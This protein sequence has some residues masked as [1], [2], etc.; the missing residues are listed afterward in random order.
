MAVDYDLVII[1]G[2][3][4]GVSAA[5]AAVQL[6][7]RV[8]LVVSPGAT[9]RW[10]RQRQTWVEI[11]RLTQ[12]LG[13]WPQKLG[14][15]GG[16]SPAAR[17]G[18]EQLLPW[19]ES[20][21]ATL[22]GQD[23]LAAVA[24]LGV[25]VIWG[26]GQFGRS[27][28]LHFEAATRH[29]RSRAYLIAL[30]AELESPA[31][32]GLA[33]TDYLSQSTLFEQLQAQQ[34]PP[35][36]AILGSGPTATELAQTLARLGSQVSL[37]TQH[38]RILPQ[39]DAEAAFLVQAQLEA[40]GIQV[41]CHS[42]VQEVSLRRNG[43]KVL[44]TA[45]GEVEAG[46]ILLATAA[47]PNLEGLNLAAVGVKCSRQGIWVN[48]K[49]QT[50]HAQIYVCGDAIGG[51]SLPHLARYEAA[52]A[53]KNALFWPRSPVDY[54]PIP[55]AIFTDPQLARVGLTEAQAKRYFGPKLQ[56]FKQP[57]QGLMQAQIRGT[58][59]GL[60]KLICRQ[61]GEILGAHLVGP[62]AAELIPLLALAVKQRLKVTAL[63]DL[64]AISPSFAEVIPQ[65]ARSGLTDTQ[66][67]SRRDWLECFFHWRRGRLW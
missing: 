49:L 7:A 29:L 44:R 35:D 13:E 4:A 15:R 63:A 8:A 56:I 9:Q 57:Y 32:P 54:R 14:S 43:R 1:G 31:I 12:Q 51:Y 28:Q 64:V 60:C 52:I 10:H 33:P 47:R 21:A 36:L 23:D 16:P 34:F 61:R 58:P 59:T 26:P 65:T 20:I 62:G 37:I 6:Q 66:H 18:L 30:E 50:S 67:P 39:E 38:S 3:E 11:G 17:L 40:E 2:S 45:R 41:L 24:G 55:W 5:V 48:Q 46:E 22:E 53:L 25:D 27:P 42:P 19:V